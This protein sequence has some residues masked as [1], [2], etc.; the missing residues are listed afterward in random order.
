MC[1]YM[2]KRSPCRGG[3]RT[4]RF[5]V[6]CTIPLP[7]TNTTTRFVWIRAHHDVP[8][9]TDR[10][11]TTRGGTC[12]ARP[13]T[14]IRAPLRP[15]SPPTATGVHYAGTA[16]VFGLDRTVRTVATVDGPHVGTARPQPFWPPPTTTTSAAVGPCCARAAHAVNIGSPLGRPITTDTS[17]TVGVVRERPASLL[18]AQFVAPCFTH[19]RRMRTRAHHDAPLHTD[20]PTTTRGGTSAA[21]PYAGIAPLRA[22]PAV[23]HKSIRL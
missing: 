18:P 5:L 13:Y 11:T 22:E 23:V 7:P 20:R 14:G 17:A 15:P 2:R 9:H 8:L 16:T 6:I 19:T 21:R 4:A 10:P 1:P 12:A 3:S